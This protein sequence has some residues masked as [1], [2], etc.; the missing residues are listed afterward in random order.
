MMST[1]SQRMPLNYHLFF[2][3]LI[4]LVMAGCSYESGGLSSV[5]CDESDPGVC[6]ADA[7][8]IDGYCVARDDE[9][10]EIEDAGVVR[11]A[12]PVDTDP[13]DVGPADT[14]SQDIV[15][16]DAAPI[17]TGSRDVGPEDIGAEDIGAADVG[18]DVDEPDCSGDESLCADH[19][20]DTNDHL[21]HCGEC[22]MGCTAPPNATAVCDQGNC[23][24]ICDD[25]R[26]ECSGQCIDTDSDPDHCGGCDSPCT[27]GT[28]CSEANCEVQCGD[29]LLE[30]QDACVD[31]TIHD[32]HCGECG[33]NCTT[34]VAGAD[35]SCEDE[36]CITT[37][38]DDSH[39]LCDDH[40][41]CADTTTD[42]EHCGV[43]GND[44]SASD[45]PEHSSPICDGGSCT[46]QCDSDYEE[47]NGECIAE[48]TPCCGDDEKECDGACI[49]AEE[50]C[51]DC[52]PNLSD[53]FGGGDGTSDT[54]Y[55]ICTAQQL[56]LVGGDGHT[57]GYFALAADIDLQDLG[58]SLSLIGSPDGS[59]SGSFDGDGYTIANLSISDD[60]DEV[61]LFRRLGSDGVITGITLNDVALDVEGEYVGALA[62]RNWGHIDDASVTGTI[63]GDDQRTGGLV[64]ENHGTITGSNA[65]VAVTGDNRRTGGL[66]GANFGTI[67]NSNATGDVE[68]H[69]TRVGGLVGVN[70]DGIITDSYATGNVTGTNNRVGGL[71]GENRNASIRASYA[72]GDVSAE[73]DDEVG[74]L[75]GR[76]RSAVIRDGYATG[77]VVGN[78]EVG[79][80]V[81][82]NR[83]G[84]GIESSHSVGHVAVSGWR[85]GGLVG[86]ESGLGTYTTRSYW[87]T[88]TSDQ[89]DS[90]GGSGLE[91]SQFDDTDN[92]DQ[93]NFTDVW[94]IGEI[95]GVARPV[96]R[97]QP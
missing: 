18:T 28:V 53:E 46:F 17:D 7:H 84:A 34:D 5:A 52:N 96:L 93:W 86:R 20:V 31:P 16:P 2:V 22:D 30:C 38:T 95:D 32:E 77:T 85:I 78:R 65:A 51:G 45:I 19:C 33:N 79:G 4:S 42:D 15:T 44:C 63:T 55:L 91:T 36:S 87:D 57:E 88:E 3:L 21:D 54:P 68:G 14:G 62:G 89:S 72:T 61:G 12:G 67:E 71:V 66:V 94:E 35:S 81:G 1:D 8:C 25:G 73:S 47:C 49:D 9:A 40:G 56:N 41:V 24:F 11:D 75:V 90:D 74:G 83:S 70:R 60:R 39:T 27:D 58:G 29:E 82:R 76:N 48:G 59:F 43:C 6:G 50:F 37:C 92:F 69:H 80:L 64:G 26:Q 10:P 97:W 23:T 13:S